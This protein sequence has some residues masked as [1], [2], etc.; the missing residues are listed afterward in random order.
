MQ[1]KG[2]IVGLCSHRRFWSQNCHCF[3]SSSFQK[4]SIYVP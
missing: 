3:D 4:D 2:D 1:L